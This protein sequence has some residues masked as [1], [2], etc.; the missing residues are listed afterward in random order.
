MRMSFKFACC[1]AR[2]EIGSCDGV[3]LFDDVV[4]QK[5]KRLFEHGNSHLDLS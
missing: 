5:T 3:S 4:V 2:D 1:K